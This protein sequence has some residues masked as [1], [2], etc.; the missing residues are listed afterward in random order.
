MIKQV[1]INSHGYIL[2]GLHHQVENPKGIVVM[3]HG[4]TGHKNENGYLFKQLSYTLNKNNYDAIRFDFMGSGDSDGEFWEMDYSTELR[5]ARCILDYAKQINRGEELILIGFSYGG[6]IA[7][8][9]SLEYKEDLTKLILLAPAANMPSLAKNLF[10]IPERYID[11][12]TI[13]MGGYT[14]VKSF[15]ESFKDLA[16]YD[17]CETFTKPVLIVH[18]GSDKSVPL[19]RSKGYAEKYSDCKYVIIP[20]SEHCFQSVN[21]RQALHQ[22][23]IEFL[24]K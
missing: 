15:I 20:N 1:E 14:M 8:R 21:Q 16:P 12:N 23:I 2:R 19:E 9:I 3:F 4:F 13:D 7:S 22:E 5:D 11:E 17:N 6:L 18:G 24:N 10:S